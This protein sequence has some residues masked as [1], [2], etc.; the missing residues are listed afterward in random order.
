MGTEPKCSPNRTSR[1]E[2][3]IT[4]AL[5]NV[6]NNAANIGEIT[7]IAPSTSSTKI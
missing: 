3:K 2:L 1:A 5:A 6:C 4:T 7:P